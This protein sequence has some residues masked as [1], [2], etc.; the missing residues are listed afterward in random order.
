M[1]LIL[2]DAAI[3][4]ALLRS[5]MDYDAETGRLVWTDCNHKTRNGSEVGYLGPQGYRITNLGKRPMCVHRLIWLYAYGVWPVGEI[6]HINGIRSDNRLCNLREA[7]REQNARNRPAQRGRAIKGI[8]FARGKY[9]AQIRFGGK[10]IYLGRF[11]T[12]EQAG[13]AYESAARDLHGEF[14]RAS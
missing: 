11:D 8:T 4:Q 13:A 7:T 10:N 12:A 6:D 2:D 9:Q 1:P 14:V 3:T 5:K